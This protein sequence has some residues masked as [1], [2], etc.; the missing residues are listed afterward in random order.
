MEHKIALLID[1]DNASSGL[2]DAVMQKAGK[3]GKIP[4]RRIYG[5]WKKESLKSWESK[6][7]QYALR[8]IQQFDFTQGK[9][10]TDMALIIDGVEM[11]HTGL[12]NTFI[13]MS[14]DSDYT[15]LAL[16]LREKGCYVIGVGRSRTS[17]AFRSSCH[18]FWQTEQYTPTVLPKKTVAVKVKNTPSVG[19]SSR[20]SDET[21][22]LHNLLQEAYQEAGTDGQ[23]ISLC[24]AGTYLH[25]ALPEF[26][27]KDYGYST[28]SKMLKAFPDRYQVKKIENKNGAGNFGYRC[29]DASDK[30]THKNKK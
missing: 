28:L 17:A 11:Y 16:Y 4:M 8:P 12:Y 14:S 23:Y 24:A 7:A 2:L 5:N 1:A 19:S 27:I 29:I 9:N 13:I 18:E 25:S 21:E 6:I 30:K 20:N 26:R 3:L 10:A 22:H 15:P